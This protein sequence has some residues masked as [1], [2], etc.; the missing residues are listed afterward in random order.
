MTP[1]II[2]QPDSDIKYRHL[3]NIRVGRAVYKYLPKYEQPLFICYIKSVNQANE[4]FSLI[5]L[6]DVKF[7][8]LF[9]LNNIS[10]H[11]PTFYEEIPQSHNKDKDAGYFKLCGEIINQACYSY[12]QKP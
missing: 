8:K 10:F 7:H 3:T 1:E 11:D 6:C 4:T 2:I 9:P 12:Y 5:N